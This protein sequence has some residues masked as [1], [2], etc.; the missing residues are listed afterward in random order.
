LSCFGKLNFVFFFSIEI[1]QATL[2]AIVILSIPQLDLLDVADLLE[3]IFIILFPNYNLGQGLNDIY[4]NSVL[5]DLCAPIVQFCPFFPNPCC[6]DTCG[7]NCVYWT[8]N[9]LGWDKPGI[10]RFIVFMG[11]QSIVSFTILLFIDYRIISKIRYFI[12]GPVQYDRST[13]NQF[14]NNIISTTVQ[15]TDNVQIPNVNHEDDDVVEEAERIKNT[16]TFVLT[17][18]DVLVLN[19]VE[20]VYNGMFHA[21]DQVSLGVKQRECFGLLGVNG[22]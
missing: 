15:V 4:Q 9:Y 5:N 13:V 6:K 14:R 7:S 11:I 10:G 2:L 12:C 19:Q 1:G 21:V 16:H 8:T 22:A 17:E 18:T 3:W 20:K